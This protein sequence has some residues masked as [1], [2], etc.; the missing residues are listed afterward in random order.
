MVNSDP[1]NFNSHFLFNPIHLY[2]KAVRQYILPSDEKKD[3]S[4]LRK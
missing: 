1:Y 4:S 2:E 3:H